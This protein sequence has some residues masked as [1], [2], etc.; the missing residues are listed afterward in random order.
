MPQPDLFFWRKPYRATPIGWR[1]Q[2]WARARG[3]GSRIP[4]QANYIWSGPENHC[5]RSGVLAIPEAQTTSRPRSLPN[6]AS[7]VR[8]ATKPTK[9]AN[10]IARCAYN[11]ILPTA[12][13]VISSRS[14][15]LPGKAPEYEWF[16]RPYLQTQL[17]L[18]GRFWGHR[19]NC[20]LVRWRNW[21]TPFVRASLPPRSFPK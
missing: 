19:R 16:H 15:G 10:G 4:I 3:R 14:T 9:T 8:P 17:I 20:H 18:A 5:V 2:S 1:K 7:E 11:A 12:E 13:S 21:S 6:T